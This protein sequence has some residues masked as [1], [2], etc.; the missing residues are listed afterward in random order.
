MTARL[1]FLALAAFWITMNVML[2]RM[3]YGSQGGDMPVPLQL[4]WRKVLT[5]PDASSLS[6]YQNGDRTGYCE[7]ST[8]VGQQMATMDDTKPPPEGF[9]MRAGYQLHFAGNISLGDF[10]NRLKFDGRVTFSPQRTW[11]EVTLKVTAHQATVEIHSLAT[12]D[13][14]R[15]K[16][17][18]DAGTIERDL[19]FSA[20]ANPNALVQAFTGNLA[21]TLLGSMDL[22]DFAP[23]AG[24]QNLEWVARRT[25][26]KIGAEYVPV[27]RLETTVVGHVISVDVSTLGEIL[28]IRLPGNVTAIIDELNKP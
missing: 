11:Q 7:L 4:V 28:R 2:W 15:V 21:D 8:S 6:V 18:G 27:Y 19:P 9:A 5:A 12:N 22:P 1:S 26:L 20:L 17:S 13:M 24:G 14:V 25:R 3:E 16:I 10:T 23:M